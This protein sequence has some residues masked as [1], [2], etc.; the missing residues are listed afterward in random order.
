MMENS[1][2]YIC[3]VHKNAQKRDVWLVAH[4]GLLENEIIFFD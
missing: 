3:K 1:M 2:L 4:S